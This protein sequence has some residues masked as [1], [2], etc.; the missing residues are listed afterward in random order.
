MPSTRR[1]T[2]VERGKKGQQKFQRIV[3]TAIEKDIEAMVL[4]HY[5][6]PAIHE[7]LVK[8]HK[9]RAPSL[10]TVETWY[11]KLSPPDVTGAWSFTE[12]DEPELVL[13]VLAALI[14]ETRGRRKELTNA[15]AEWI[16]KICGAAPGIDPWYAYILARLYMLR[17]QAG[18]TS[19]DIDAYLAYAP[20]RGEQ[21]AQAYGQALEEGW[22]SNV[23]YMSP[24]AFR[25]FE[26]VTLKRAPSNP[27]G[28]KA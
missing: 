27:R 17:K 13:P 26:V 10:R 14:S 11:R 1:N 18:L 3:G 21:E 7:E 12:A 4:A 5:K 20:W 22:V 6:P 2:K 16:A 19:L 24:S 9:S 23:P 8:R 28:V 15:E 25:E